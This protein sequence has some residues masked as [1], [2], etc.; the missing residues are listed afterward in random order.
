[1]SDYLAVY[2]PKCLGRG[3]EYISVEQITRYLT[4][5]RGLPAARPRMGGGRHT[6]RMDPGQPLQP[7]ESARHSLPRVDPGS[8]AEYRCRRGPHGSV[9]PWA[10]SRKAGGILQGWSARCGALDSKIEHPFS[11]ESGRVF[12]GPTVELSTGREDVEAHCQW[13]GLASLT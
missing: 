10:V 8:K 4:G 5:V 3:N 12:P 6:Y 13:Q 7:P 11:W 1:M 2:V 9:P